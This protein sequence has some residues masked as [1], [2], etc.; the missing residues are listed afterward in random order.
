MS[1]SE[2]G[3]GAGVSLGIAMVGRVYTIA[4]FCVTGTNQARSIR[5]FPNCC[6]SFAAAASGDRN[7]CLANEFSCA[8]DALNVAQ[9]RDDALGD[10]IAY[11]SIMA[12]AP[13]HAI[14]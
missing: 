5:R 1:R 10:Q 8:S 14:A 4:D 3:G 7:A 6:Q 11:Q 13:L 2:I 9:R 12:G